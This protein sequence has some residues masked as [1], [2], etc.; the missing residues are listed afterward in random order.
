[1]LQF[2]E[3]LNPVNC[4]DSFLSGQEINQYSHLSI[5]ENC[6]TMFAA[7]DMV[8]ALFGSAA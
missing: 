2:L 1:M 6:P 5:S 7:E 8:L 4:I 3:H